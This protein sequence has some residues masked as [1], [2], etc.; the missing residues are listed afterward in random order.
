VV[1]GF[2]ACF[3]DR[4]SAKDP[5]AV[6]ASCQRAQA[7]SG[8]DPQVGRVVAAAADSARRRNFSEVFERT[9][10]FEVAVFLAC[11][12]LVFLL[13]PTHGRA[14]ERARAAVPA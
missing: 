13:P 6:P 9:L 2:E 3:E 5:A 11:F 14:A 10:L 1:A 4:S 7:Q 8:S 12:L